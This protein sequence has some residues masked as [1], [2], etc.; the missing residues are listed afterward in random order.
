MLFAEEDVDKQQ[1]LQSSETDLRAKRTQLKVVSPEES[2]PQV[3]NMPSQLIPRTQFRTLLDNGIGLRRPLGRAMKRGLDLLLSIPMVF[4]VLPPLCVVVKIAHLLQSPGPLFYRQVRSG[5]G[6][7]RFS[8]FKFR[9]MDLPPPGQT[10]VEENAGRRIFPLGTL[11]RRSKLDEIPQFINVLQGAMSVVGPRPHHIVDCETFAKQVSDYPMRSIAKPGIT[12]L[13]QYSEFR[14][15]FEWNCVESRVSKDLAYIRDWSLLLDIKLI[16]STITIVSIRVLRGG[17]RRLI[18][19]RRKTERE[20]DTQ[21]AV[22][23]PDKSI[24][25]VAGNVKLSD[26]PEQK[27]AA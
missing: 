23:S 27:R 3:S 16:R 4:L 24:P 20:R 22:F 25:T 10:D 26:L 13:A 8:I 14:G 6:R 19:G 7:T 18:I 15:D 12:G 21:L 9:T 11:L 2:A 1:S 17:L 5:R